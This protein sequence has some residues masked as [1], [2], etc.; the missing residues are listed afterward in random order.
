MSLTFGHFNRDSELDQQ[1]DLFIKCFPE[2]LDAPT[3]SKT[4][5]HWKFQGFPG[6]P[7]AYEYTAHQDGK[8]AGYYAAIPFRYV[9]KGQAMTAAMVC[10]VMTH[11]E[12][13]G[14]GIFT[15]LGAYSTDQLKAAGLN[16][17]TGYPIRPQV[18]PGHLKVGWQVAFDL[19]VYVCP[20]KSETILQQKGLGFLSPIVDLGISLFHTLL[21]F[22]RGPA[23]GKT[24]VRHFNSSEIEQITGYRE[25]F[26]DWTETQNNFLVKDQEF[27]RWRLGAPEQSYSLTC[28]YAGEQLVAM[29]IS[30]ITD[31]QGIPALAILDLMISAR[32]HKFSSHLFTALYDL[33]RSGQAE[34]LAGMFSKFW[35]S[36]Y[37]LLQYGFLRSPSV[38]KLIIKPLA[39]LPSDVN[40][41]EEQQ[42][43]MMWIDSDDL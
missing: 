33:A 39:H 8:L 15:K 5:Y 3:S 4:H 19:P 42:W 23:E 37:N 13:Q 14:K 30:K 43:H 40:L 36:R 2:T 20:L 10:D 24:V 18:I 35:A 29:A 34:V 21:K 28:V 41:F 38:F 11:P 16:F 25:F 27:L 32:G 9:V 22:F 17:A 26:T 7:P 31:L 6:E 1:R 12:M